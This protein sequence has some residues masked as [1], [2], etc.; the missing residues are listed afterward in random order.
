M[1]KVDGKLVFKA[2]DCEKKKKFACKRAALMHVDEECEIREQKVRKIEE[3]RRRVEEALRKIEEERA[4]IEAERIEAERIEYERTKGFLSDE[5]LAK[6]I[7]CSY[8]PLGGC[9]IM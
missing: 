1:N 5:E 6:K 9:H 7:V 2:D 8:V 4:R 3:E